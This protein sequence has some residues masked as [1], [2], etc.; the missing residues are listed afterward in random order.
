MSNT[1][2][3]ENIPIHKVSFSKQNKADFYATVKER[4][5]AYFKQKGI[6]RFANWTMHLKILLLFSVYAACYAAIMSNA[7]SGTALIAWYSLLGMIMGLIGFNFSHDVMHGAYFANPKL[8]RI[9]SY[10]FDFNGTSS[11]VWKYT[12]NFKHHTYTNI[13]GFDEDIDKAIILRLSPRDKVY[14]FHRFQFIYGPILYALTT[15]N[16]ALYSDYKYVIEQ[17]KSGDIPKQEAALFFALK[18]ANLF[19]FLLLPMLLLDAPVWQVILGFFSMHFAAGLTIAF[20]FQLAHIVEGVEFPFPDGQNAI[21]M[22]WAEHELRTTSNF[23][24]KSLLCTHVVGGLNFQIEHHLFTYVCHVHYPDISPIVKKT[25]EEFGLP[26]HEHETLW[27]AM[28]SHIRL[29]KK[30]GNG[31]L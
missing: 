16:W 26:Y 12:H 30:F 8:N 19:V 11:Y 23:A 27:K 6:T 28:T 24:T 3:N 7:F 22:P 17:M 9:L 2:I 21:Q 18:A 14:P 4:V 29:L 5:E 25:A 20:I 15:V 31:E 13:P 10:V 1:T